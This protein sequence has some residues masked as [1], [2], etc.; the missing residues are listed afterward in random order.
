MTDQTPAAPKAPAKS[1]AELEADVVRLRTELAATVDQFSERISPSYQVG[2][3]MEATK[4]AASDARSFVTGAGLPA[5]DDGARARNVKMLL[6]AAGAALAFVTL[7]I[8]RAVQRH[9]SNG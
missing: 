5:D 1:R 2:R 7:T 6:G 3:V 4:A 9:R 8:V